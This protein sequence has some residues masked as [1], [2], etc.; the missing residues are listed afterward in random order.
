MMDFE[1]NQTYLSSEHQST[2][3]HILISEGNTTDTKVA[4]SQW[5]EELFLDILSIEYQLVRTENR[6]VDTLAIRYQ[7][8]RGPEHML[9]NLS[10]SALAMNL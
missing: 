8:S 9:M 1:L 4:R 10:L 5:S 7:S 6:L 2:E 3:Y